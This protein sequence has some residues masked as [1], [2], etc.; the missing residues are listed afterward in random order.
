MSARRCPVIDRAYRLEQRFNIAIL[1][2]RTPERM[3]H[4]ERPRISQ[5]LMPDKICRAERR[6]VIGS[7]RLNVNFLER[8]SRA[9]LSI[10]NAV[11]G[12]ASGQAQ[13]L[14]FCPFPQVVEDM[15][16]A[17]LVNGLQ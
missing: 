12:A 11:H 7:A 2:G 10:R 6:A 9:N 13:M 8:C 5:T 14:R 16:E 4:H 3:I 1:V 15:E 17:G